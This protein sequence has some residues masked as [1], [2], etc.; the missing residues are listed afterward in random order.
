MRKNK[1]YWVIGVMT[2]VALGITLDM[3]YHTA[4]KQRG[5]LLSLIA[6]IVSI[7]RWQRPYSLLCISTIRVR[8]MRSKTKRR[9]KHSKETDGCGRS[10]GNSMA[11]DRCG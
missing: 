1:W 5:E 3:Y 11:H 10:R 6:V 2:A 8:T 7:L 4:R 9:K